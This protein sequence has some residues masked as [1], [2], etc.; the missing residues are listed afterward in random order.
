MNFS[1]FV[2]QKRFLLAVKTIKCSLFVTFCNIYIQMKIY[3]QKGLM[4]FS[5]LLQKY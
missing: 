1:N 5:K 3:K 2:Q 4:Q